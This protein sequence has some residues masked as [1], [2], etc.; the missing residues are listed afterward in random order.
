MTNF[1]PFNDIELIF[2]SKAD[3]IAAI[4]YALPAPPMLVKTPQ[5]LNIM[6][7]D[8]WEKEMISHDLIK[9]WVATLFY[10]QSLDHKGVH[11]ER[12][13]QMLQDEQ[14]EVYEK[15][16][17]HQKNFL[18]HYLNAYEKAIIKYLHLFK[19]GPSETDKA[20]KETAEHPPLTAYILDMKPNVM[21]ELHFD[22]IITTEILDKQS[23]KLLDYTME[24]DKEQEKCNIN[25]L[26]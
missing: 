7:G 21:K 17:F 13:K 2:Q 25:I 26:V 4:T 16:A 6:T 3:V 20:L 23:K 15:Y 12:V 9:I 1:I 18:L 10:I 22:Q 11:M 14:Q 24:L 8:T 5:L 19:V